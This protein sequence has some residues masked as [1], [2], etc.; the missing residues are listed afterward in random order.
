MRGNKAINQIIGM[1]A[2]YMIMRESSRQV[3]PFQSFK[4]GESCARLSVVANV[5]FTFLRVHACGALLFG[6]VTV[7][8]PSSEDWLESRNQCSRALQRQWMGS[9]PSRCQ[10][11]FDHKQIIP[12]CLLIDNAEAVL[13]L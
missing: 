9:V 8:R 4:L 1:T 6:R 12:G 3:Y 10:C 13:V 5:V 11:R 2:M 7:I